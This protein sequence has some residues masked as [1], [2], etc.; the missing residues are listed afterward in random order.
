M[1]LTLRDARILRDLTLSK[2]LSRD[3][4]ISLGYFD[5]VSRCNRTLRRLCVTGLA[6]SVQT[7]FHGQRLY[8]STKA[9]AEVVGARMARFLTAQAGPPRFLLH[10]LAVTDVRIAFLNSC[11]SDWRF[12]AQL[13]HTFTFHGAAFEVRPDGMALINEVPVLIEVDLGHCSMNRFR[14]KLG[15]YRNYNA[16]G[17][18]QSAY[19]ASKLC[20][21][22]VTTGER[23]KGHLEA[24][25]EAD[26][27]FVFRTFSEIGAPSPEV[28]S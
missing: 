28:W 6:R 13:R 27:R 4:L 2:V 9:A 8:C 24:L 19:N 17:C 16:S 12:E 26:E 23:R 22:V 5:S 20:L 15:A 25:A 3:Q 21:T 7:P 11:A 1:K 14:S 18:F 10:A